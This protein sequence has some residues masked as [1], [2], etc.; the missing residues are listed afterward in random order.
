MP[1][2]AE[3]NSAI[4]TTLSAATGIVRSQDYDE[5]TEGIHGADMPL[6]QVYPESG[7]TDSGTA[8]DR[9][10]FGAGR[11][12]TTMTFHADVYVKQRANIGEDM[13]A[14]VPQIDN[15]ITVLEE[16]TTPPFFS[17]GTDYDE[18][19]KSFSW[20][21]ERSTFIYGDRQLPY[22]GVRF[23]LEMVVF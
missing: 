6:L 5:L 19:I 21:W 15:I 12:Q 3:I 8:T 13:A 22:I 9:T 16:Q 11:R 10:T 18:Y 2:I 20:N 1:S 14:L 23:T 7:N 4:E 17:L